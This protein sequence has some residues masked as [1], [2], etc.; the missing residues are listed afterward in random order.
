MKSVL[1]VYW[2]KSVVLLV[3]WVRRTSF[4]ELRK[5]MFGAVEVRETVRVRKDA[6]YVPVALLGLRRGNLV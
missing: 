3:C 1:F 6:C 5:L 4:C 2:K